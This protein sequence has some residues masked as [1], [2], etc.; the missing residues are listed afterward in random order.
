[1]E[2]TPMINQLRNRVD[3]EGFGQS[4]QLEVSDVGDQSF[5]DMVQDAIN[6]VDQAQKTA[7]QNVESI[8]TGQSDNIHEAMIS[9]EKAQLSFQLM[10]EVRNKAVE[11]YKELSRMQI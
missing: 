10:M 9:M 6:S 5:S 11:T 7:D 8:V 3:N 2:I 4:K 1:M